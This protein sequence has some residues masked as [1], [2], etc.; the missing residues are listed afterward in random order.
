MADFVPGQ[1]L[2]R[3]FYTEVVAP[4]VG[5][6]HAAALVG[7]GSDVLGYDTERSTDHDWGPRC[8][9]FVPASAVEDVRTRVLAALPEHY[10]GW[11]VAIGRDGQPPRPKV[12]VAS[13]SSWLGEQ[14]GWPLPDAVDGLELAATDWLLLPQQRLLEITAG[15]VFADDDGQLERLRHRLAWYPDPVWWW[16]LACQWRRLAQEE[17]FVSRTAEVGDDVGSRVVCGRLVRDCMR[18]ALLTARRYAPYAKWLGTAFGRLPDGDGLGEHLRLAMAADTVAGREAALGRSYERLAERFNALTPDPPLDTS[19][20]AFF[21]R[22]A[23]VLGAD[24]FAAAALAR[25]RAP[26]LAAMPLVGS[27][28]LLVDSTDV[29]ATPE[30]TAAMRSF[31]TALASG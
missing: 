23:R 2:S 30:R 27:V 25:V 29:L 31:Y 6:P 4:R 18:L 5:V 28:D 3:A 9:L 21:D 11:P 19:L 26:A 24:R 7:T 12:I 17:P 15:A 20:R 10:Q 13:L 14:L 8:T 1:R 22:P 16:L